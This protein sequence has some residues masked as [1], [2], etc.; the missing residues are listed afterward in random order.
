MAYRAEPLACLEGQL[1]HDTAHGLSATGDEMLQDRD[2]LEITGKPMEVPVVPS[3]PGQSPVC[4][5]TRSCSICPSGF[6]PKKWHQKE[7]AGQGKG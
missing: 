7:E 5:H 1:R 3:V 4:P 6:V 2:C